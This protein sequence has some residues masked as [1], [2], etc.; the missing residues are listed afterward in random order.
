MATVFVRVP[1][2]P[3]SSEFRTVPVKEKLVNPPARFRRVLF[4]HYERPVNIFWKGNNHSPATPKTSVS[5][6]TSQD[7]FGDVTLRAT[8]KRCLQPRLWNV[9]KHL[10]PSAFVR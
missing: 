2:G 8:E 4:P 3:A 5:P 6:V 7:T 10:L 1:A 9:Q